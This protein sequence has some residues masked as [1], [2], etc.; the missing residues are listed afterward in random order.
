VTLAQVRSELRPLLQRPL[1]MCSLP[2]REKDAWQQDYS[3]KRKPSRETS[4]P[5]GKKTEG[6]LGCCRWE[7]IWIPWSRTQG[8]NRTIGDALSKRVPFYLQ[9]LRARRIKDRTSESQNRRPAGSI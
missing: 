2:T 7:W 6:H 1:G 9:T 5:R 8:V 4:P 3:K